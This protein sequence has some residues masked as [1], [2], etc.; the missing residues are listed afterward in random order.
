LKKKGKL[1]LILQIILAPTQSLNSN[2]NNSSS[3]SF[4]SHTVL[5]I[6]HDDEIT[7]D[8]NYNDYSGNENSIFDD[9]NK[10]LI[11][12]VLSN[13]KLGMDLTKITLPTF[14]L[15]KRSLLE[16]FADCMTHPDLFLR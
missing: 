14:I 6:N 10:S 12:H 16:L 3:N 7:D 4:L 2:N 1:N 8:E 5:N 13:L 9:D 15:D 11:L